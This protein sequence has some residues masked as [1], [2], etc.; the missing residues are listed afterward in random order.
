VCRD[1]DVVAQG[2]MSLTRENAEESLE[3]A[4][5]IRDLSADKTARGPLALIIG[6]WQK[7]VLEDLAFMLLIHGRAVQF[8][9]AAGGSASDAVLSAKL[10]DYLRAVG[11]WLERTGYHN[12]GMIAHKPYY[13]PVAKA[14]ADLK[15][16]LGDEALQAGI[17]QPAANTV[18]NK[19]DPKFI[20]P[21][22]RAICG[23]P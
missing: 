18:R 14:L 5:R 16:R 20:D 10:A 2:W 17:V 8:A 22:V 4:N 19:V 21:V 12:R 7:R 6:D 9:D 23:K 15:A 1:A 13:D 3:L 11:T